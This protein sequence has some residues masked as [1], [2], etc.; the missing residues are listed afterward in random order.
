[1][2]LADEWRGHSVQSVS[3]M[4]QRLPSGWLA[5]TTIAGFVALA[6]SSVA[7]VVATAVAASIGELYRGTSLLADWMYELTH[8]PVT[9]L[10]RGSLFVSLAL[11]LSVGMFWAI[12]Y[13]LVFEPKLQNYPSWQAGAIFAMLPFVLSVS[14]FPLLVGAGLFWS[15]LRAGPFPI[16]GNLVLHLIYGATL[17]A[18]Y[19]LAADRAEAPWDRQAEATAGRQTALMG[20][21]ETAAALGILLGIIGGG[22][23]GV[24]LG[25]TLPFSAVEDLIGSWPVVMGVACALA[26]ASVGALIGSMY[27]LTDPMAIPIEEEPSKGDPFAAA[28]IPL[29]VIGFVAIII[30]SIGSALLTVGSMEHCNHDPACIE[31]GYNQAIILGL[32]ILT[33]ITVVAAIIDIRGRGRR[34][35]GAH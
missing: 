3:V 14:V 11:H 2:Q 29:F 34:S 12:F 7:L 20:R 4:A 30:V 17:G 33:V 23:I 21:A 8:N 19:G 18:I 26:G 10:G 22:V 27:G 31:H 5:R 15:E 32:S 24:A 16:M 6:V 35:K 25:Y 1:M 9:E 13:A 28:F